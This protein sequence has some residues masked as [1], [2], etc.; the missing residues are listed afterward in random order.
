MYRYNQAWLIRTR[1]RR[2]F[3]DYHLMEYDSSLY[4]FKIQI[5]SRLMIG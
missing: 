4:N 5:S 1:R 3:T 2:A